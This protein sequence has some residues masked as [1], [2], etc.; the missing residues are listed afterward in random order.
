MIYKI[1]FSKEKEDSKVIQL[2]LL[3]EYK[4]NYLV[5]KSILKSKIKIKTS[6][7]LIFSLS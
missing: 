7:K 4:E 3:K 2:I 6:I 5:E 1:P